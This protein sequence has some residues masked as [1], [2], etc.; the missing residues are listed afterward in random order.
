MA[1]EW[2][3]CG[4]DLKGDGRRETM[5]RVCYRKAALFQK[6]NNENNLEHSSFKKDTERLCI[7][8]RL[9]F[10]RCVNAPLCNV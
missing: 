2:R 7:A 4:K 9:A 5:I 10:H 1:W 8:S 6:Q 3:G